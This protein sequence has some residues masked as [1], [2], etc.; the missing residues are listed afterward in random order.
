MKQFITQ[1]RGFHGHMLEVN[2]YIYGILENG[3][4]ISIVRG[5]IKEKG[6]YIVGF[7][8]E[9]EPLFDPQVHLYL[10]DVLENGAEGRCCKFDM[11]NGFGK[12]MG[13]KI[14]LIET[15][16]PDKDFFSQYRQLYQGIPS[17]ATQLSPN[18]REIMEKDYYYFFEN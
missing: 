5:M 15:I 4:R 8:Y 9:P 3:E 13:T 6:S 10:F 12:M 14:E 16:T 11:F 18:Y 17:T 1:I 7:S 2:G